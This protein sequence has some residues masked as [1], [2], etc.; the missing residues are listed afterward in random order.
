MYRT[1]LGIVGAIVLA[2]VVAILT[3]G[4][5]ADAPASFV[6]VNGTEPKTLDPQTMTGQ[7][8]GRIADALFEG[9]TYRD[10]KSLLPMPGLAT[11]WTISPDGRTYRFRIREGA[12]WSDGVPVTAADVAWSWRRLQGADLGSEYAYI[13]H[14][15]RGAEAY[16]TYGSAAR[17]LRDEVLPAL[18]T[19]RGKHPGPIAIK[20]W[21][22]FVGDHNVTA[23]VK[24]T[25]DPA[26]V[27]LL[28]RKTGDVTR[29][30]V[31]AAIEALRREAD[32]RQAAFEHADAHFG[33]D[34]G[35][36]VDPQDDHLL[37]VELKAP[38]PYFLE[39]TSFYPA[40][41]VP[42]H[43]VAQHEDD[44]FLAGRIVSNGP[45]RLTQWRVN[46]RI[47]LEKSPTYWD[48]DAASL[49]IIDALP[50]TD[51][52]ASMNLFLTGDV[53]WA[54]GPPNE[55]VEVLRDRP[56]FRVAPGMI[57]YYYRL[58]C[59]HPVLSNP[60]VRQAL[61]MAIDRKA[62]TENILRAGQVPA[63]V[64]VPPGLPGYEAPESGLR[65]DVEAARRLLAEAGHEKGKGIGQLRLLYNT[66][67]G[68]KQIGEAIADQLRRNLGV[69]VLPLNKEWQTYQADTMALDYEIARAGWIGDYLDPN[70]FLDMWVTNGGNNQTGW[71]DPR[72]DR[73]IRQA[74]DVEAAVPSFSTWVGDLREPDR[75]RALVEA[76][77]A[78][79]DADA[80][81]V[82]GERLRLHLF[83]EAE[84][85]LFQEAF[86]II[87]IYFYVTQNLVQP[88]VEGWYSQLELPDGTRAPNFQDIHPLRGIRVTGGPR[89][90]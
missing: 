81:R 1:L 87:P 80:R 49:E 31:D 11:E 15:V 22:A 84:A 6:F 23:T 13:L 66:N 52:T 27:D 10:P 4:A 62:I 63:Y 46:E 68:H 61:S 43:V 36:Y 76:L 25:E 88:W 2:L 78:A 47:R 41:P 54:P 35:V 55:L 40:Y 12:L 26:L 16:N 51:T 38:T 56:E 65:F 42:P 64:L 14:M 37:I 17:H 45:Y 18:A 82:A 58:N 83:R 8:E 71:S 73:L 90:R 44:W 3:Y 57:V 85:L 69:D 28:A 86:P 59:T 75:A 9:L 5:S 60:K 48:P 89:A 70:T 53:D 50:V 79:P 21:I 19:L 7:P 29:A 20:T 72:Y 67:E 39:L 77:Q 34:E 74:A 33:I 24:G 30:E 32:L